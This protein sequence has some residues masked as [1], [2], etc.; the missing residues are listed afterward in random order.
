MKKLIIVD[1]D[2]PGRALALSDMDVGDAV[3][4]RFVFDAAI[5]RAFGEVAS[6]SAPVHRDSAF[7][8]EWG[9]RGPIIQGLCVSARFSR[10]IGMYLPGENGIL[11]SIE[12]KFRQPTYE[13]EALVFRAEISRLFRPAK[14]IRLILS[15]G[16]DEGIRI[17]GEAQCVIL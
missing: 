10:L 2:T 6:D 7:A 1:D 3:E 4:Q 9:F 8:N 17:Q 15:A 11:Q 16:S 14:A 12:F 13:G 5:R